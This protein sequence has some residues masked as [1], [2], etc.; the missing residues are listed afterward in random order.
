[1]SPIASVCVCSDYFTVGDDGRLCLIP[2]Q[3]GL[4]Q[5]LTFG[6]TG[7]YT[8]KKADYPWLARVRV[9]VQ[10]GGGG[11]AG[12]RASA[13]QLVAQ[14]GG[15]GGGYSERLID[16]SVL[17]ATESIVV[18]AGGAAGTATTDGGNG[19]NSSFGG[20][21]TAN[22]G[23]GGQAVMPSGNTP[24]CLSGTPGPAAGIGDI[25]QGGGPGG[26]ALRISGNEGQSGEGGESWMGHGGWQRS[27]TGGGGA[28]RGWGGGG[29][30]GFARDGDTTNGTGGGSGI[31]IVELWG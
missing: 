7:S 15:S 2:G 19:G 16:V 30:G 13:G 6:T 5:V 1:M 20:L 9:M 11:A 14:P 31:V 18:G 12:A 27:S 26:G 21:C 24:M 4:R 3:Q 29:A 8:F 25:A 10:A 28:G 17:G 23:A 22:G